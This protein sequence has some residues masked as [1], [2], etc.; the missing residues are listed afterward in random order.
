[1]MVEAGASF[2]SSRH[3]GGAITMTDAFGRAT[4][5]VA[6]CSVH[7]GPGLTNTM[8]GLTEAVK[9][10]TPLLLLA[11][12]TAAGA[13]RSN[14]RIDQGALVT[15]IGAGVARLR[16]PAT[17]LDDAAL[18]LQ[19]ATDERRPIVLMLPLDVQGAECSW[20]TLPPVQPAAQPRQP[21]AAGVRKVADLLGAS[22]RPIVIGGRGALGAGARE[23]IEELAD[24]TGALLA[25]SAVAGGLFAGNPW[26][27]G[28]TGGFATPL[29]AELVSSAD[30]LL[31]FGA[32]LNMWSTRHGR[33]VGPDA[34]VVQVDFDP[35][36][37]GSHLHADAGIVGDSAATARALTRELDRRH[38][39]REG[40]R[41][42]DLA[43]RIA[44]GGWWQQPF[45][46][47]TAR[48]GIDPRTLSIA[49][50]ELLPASRTLVV[51]SGHFMGWP[52]M[53]MATR[54]LDCRRPRRWR[55]PDVAAG[56][57][58]GGQARPQ[59]PGRRLQRRRL[60]GRGPPFRAS[61]QAN[62]HRPL[63]G[64]G[65]R[66]HCPRLWARGTHG[67]KTRG[68]G[69]GSG[70]AWGRPPQGAPDRRQNH[71]NRGRRMAPGGLQGSLT[72][73]M[74]TTVN[75]L[76]AFDHVTEGGARELRC[77]ELAYEAAAQ[78]PGLLPTRAEID[79]ER[80]HRQKDKRGL[81]IRQGEFFAHLLA[82]PTRGHQLMGAMGRPLQ[83]SMDRLRDFQQN[84]YTDLG[85]AELERRGRIGWITLKNLNSLNAEDDA[86]TK[87]LEIAVDLVL[88]DPQIEA[89]VLR[90]APMTHPRHLGRR[91]F[92]SG[93]NLTDLYHGK[94]SFIE[95]MLARE[96]GCVSKMYR[97]LSPEDPSMGDLE[98]GRMEKP[99]LA[100]V[101]AWAIGGACQWLL[102]M[103]LV[104][105]EKNS[106]F[107]L[108]ARNEGIIPGCAPLRLPRF[109]GER[110]AR[111]ALFLS[112]VFRAD[113][114]EGRMLA[115]QVLD[116]DEIESTVRRLAEELTAP[117][118]TSLIANRRAV[119]IASEPLDLF[120]RYMASYAA[121]QARCLY[122]PALIDNLER[123]WVARS[124][125]LPI[126]RG[127][128]T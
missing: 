78:F 107:S 14:F 77:A 57:R 43:E 81:E 55:A 48:D 122:S 94:I 112:R 88:L 115:D 53:Y 86:S 47:A 29:A 44:R 31:S 128:G 102:V 24:T 50:D 116:S 39:R 75:A 34:V 114:A 35:E 91:I 117:G 6:A 12:E 4:G 28:I 103:D 27:I 101:E 26:S 85:T 56:A 95:F 49:L 82:D 66:R 76:S 105:A 69:A 25:T 96:L 121:E 100:A 71:P 2:A 15:S 70:V 63:P 89:G 68:P 83:K 16:E 126:E 21:P 51:D 109:I 120:R 22:Q 87:N 52:P 124:P 61:R 73:K 59:P 104:V 37:I 1:A 106:Y 41:S 62:G 13:T 80:T 33:L 11:A 5:E 40:W 3:E 23:A 38:Q 67:P 72:T 119:R 65:L 8:T 46:E 17:A 108:P 118:R 99:F 127:I 30:L 125:Q 92:G 74:T 36:A 58:D 113:S 111:Q 10:H 19:R 84:G 7:Q 54:T 20:G 90:G 32:T 45:E 42:K 97:G 93:I 123:N 60:R 18:A 64:H 98:E 79:D 110:A 9:S